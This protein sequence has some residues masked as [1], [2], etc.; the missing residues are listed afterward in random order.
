MPVAVSLCFSIITLQKKTAENES[1][2]LMHRKGY[3]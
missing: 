3:A 2:R 1:A